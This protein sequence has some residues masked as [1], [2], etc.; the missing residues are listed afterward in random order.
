MGY[1]DQLIIA[2][3]REGMFWDHTVL[4]VGLVSRAVDYWKGKE[5]Q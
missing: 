4:P 2:H 5:A 1:Y 3:H